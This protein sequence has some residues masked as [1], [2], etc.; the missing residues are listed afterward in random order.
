MNRDYYQKPKWE[1]EFHEDSTGRFPTAEFLDDLLPDR[2]YYANRALGRLEE[3]GE[4]L[5][6]PQMGNLRDKIR[7]LRFRA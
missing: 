3:H 7:E 5:D 4:L 6:R 1:V 2:R